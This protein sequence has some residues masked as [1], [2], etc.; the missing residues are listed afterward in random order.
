MLGPSI[1]STPLISFQWVTKNKHL[2]GILPIN[3]LF[4]IFQEVEKICKN[5][6]EEKFKKT[7]TRKWKFTTGSDLAMPRFRPKGDGYGLLYED[8]GKVVVWNIRSM[9]IH[10]Q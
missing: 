7:K 2:I 1:L 10:A 5:S 9:H 8:T 3:I 6:E 4:A